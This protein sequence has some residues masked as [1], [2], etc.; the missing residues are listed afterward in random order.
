MALLSKS[1]SWQ[2]MSNP[3]DYWQQINLFGDV[4]AFMDE[5]TCPLQVLQ[6]GCVWMMASFVPTPG[7]LMIYLQPGLLLG[8]QTKGLWSLSLLKEAP[9]EGQPSMLFCSSILTFDH[10]LFS[11]KLP[12]LGSI[13]T[14]LIS[15][16]CALNFAPSLCKNL[17]MWWG[18]HGMFP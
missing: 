10:S 13:H 15:L 6:S 16:A 8:G 17:V 4:M 2:G 18:G 11:C 3:R 9:E 1:F 7:V 12:A 5:P 14:Q